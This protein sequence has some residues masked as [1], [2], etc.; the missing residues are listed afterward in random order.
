MDLDQALEELRARD[1]P[2]PEPLRLPTEE[3]VA[4]VEA[5]LAF[6]FPPQY[7][8]FLLEASNVTCGDRE[9]GLVLPGLQ[10]NRSLRSIA[11][12]GWLAGVPKAHLSFCEDNGNY[13]TLSASGQLGYFDHD[14]RTHDVSSCDFKDWILD[15]W[16]TSDGPV[17]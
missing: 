14:D 5:E 15:D 13:F 7:R 11:Q 9:P 8:R 1:E 4:A 16:L 10:R 17:E 3:E 6:A 2:V 12:S